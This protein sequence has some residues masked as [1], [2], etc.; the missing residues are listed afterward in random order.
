MKRMSC[1]LLLGIRRLGL[2]PLFRRFLRLSHFE[3]WDC[4]RV[5]IEMEMNYRGESDFEK[6]IHP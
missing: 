6:V 4:R 2:W 5:F 1:H 3:C